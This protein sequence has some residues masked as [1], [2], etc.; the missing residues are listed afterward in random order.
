[1]VVPQVD[2]HRVRVRDFAHACADG[3]LHGGVDE[4][5]EAVEREERHVAG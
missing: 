5:Y 3:L 4:R 2:D 1:V